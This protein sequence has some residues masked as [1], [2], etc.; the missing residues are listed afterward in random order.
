M[1]VPSHEATVIMLEFQMYIYPCTNPALQHLITYP[2]RLSLAL[3][4][5][6]LAP[7]EAT[8]LFQIIDVRQLV[9]HLAKEYCP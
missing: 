6:G 8:A 2:M 5:S 1:T 7:S 3:L 4:A 9:F